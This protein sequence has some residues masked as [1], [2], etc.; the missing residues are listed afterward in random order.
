MEKGEKK[1]ESMGSTLRLERGWEKTTSQSEITVIVSGWMCQGDFREG[2]A[3]LAPAPHNRLIHLLSRQT[4]NTSYERYIQ[5]TASCCN[6]LP[7]IYFTF[8]SKAN[9]QRLHIINEI[10][11]PN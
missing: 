11:L 3:P 10:D 4:R 8:I 5:N 7:L 2:L 6:L 9:L 1:A